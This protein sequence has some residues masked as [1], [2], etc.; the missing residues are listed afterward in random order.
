MS[1][2]IEP[3]IKARVRGFLDAQGANYD[4]LEHERVFTMA[5]CEPIGRALGAPHCKNLVLTN[6]R[7]SCFYLLLTDEKPFCTA[8]ASRALGVSRLSFASREDLR[9]LLG[10]EP[11]AASPL[12]LMFD[13]EGRVRLAVDEAVARWPRVCLHP[14]DSTASLAMDTRELLAL[15]RGPM[16]HD[17]D[18]VSL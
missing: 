5:E 9:A 3:D 2:C 1:A 6:R 17:Y 4:W 12:A 8:R 18:L 10:V 13:G 15:C 16:A 14:G 7:R 11:G